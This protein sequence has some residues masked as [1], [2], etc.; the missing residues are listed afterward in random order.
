MRYEP[1]RIV[2]REHIDAMMTFVSVVSDVN[3]KENILPVVW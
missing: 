1:P 3:R 2:R